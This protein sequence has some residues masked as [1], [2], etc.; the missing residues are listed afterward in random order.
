MNSATR[1]NDKIQA[2]HTKANPVD[3]VVPKKNR[4]STSPSRRQ[5]GS[6]KAV[7]EDGGPYKH[8]Q[9]KAVDM[10]EDAGLQK[11]QDNL[12][13]LVGFSSNSSAIVP[14]QVL[15]PN[16]RQASDS[17]MSFTE[18]TV[19]D[20]LLQVLEQTL[21]VYSCSEKLAPLEII[22]NIDQ[23]EL[24]IFKEDVIVPMMKL[25][26]QLVN[27]K[28]IDLGN[29]PLN[30]WL[31][32][33]IP[34][35]SRVDEMQ[36]GSSFL[37]GTYELS[38]QPIPGSNGEQFH[39]LKVFHSGFDMPDDTERL[40]TVRF[41]DCTSQLD[42][43]Q[44]DLDDSEFLKFNQL[45]P[46]DMMGF[47]STINQKIEPHRKK[48]VN[49][50]KII[51]GYIIGGIFFLALFATILAFLVSAWLSLIVVVIYFVGLFFIQQ[52]TS[53][54]TAEM[55]KV[56]VF[57]LAIILH[58]LNHSLLVP[59]FKLRAKIG[60][61]AQWVEFHSLRQQEPVQLD[62]LTELKEKEENV[63]RSEKGGLLADSKEFENS[64]SGIEL[65]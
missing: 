10:S 2:V 34:F 38:E 35:K 51:M 42:L 18:M 56:I 7:G 50:I 46:E 65:V 45:P 60:H 31:D 3:N 48:L 49:Q 62:K 25:P 26:P 47:V 43:K 12:Y 58:N 55:E 40:Q 5:R 32:N 28:I 41:T 13:D 8:K 27:Q 16:L 9:I 63:E 22:H 53:K 36:R 15:S 44:Y 1:M 19:D 64:N 33:C 39:T 61:M 30:P 57:N 14:A 24:A 20:L 29:Y 59:Q 11:D 4:V 21:Q 17:A 23:D 54:V 37:E 52:K 6:I